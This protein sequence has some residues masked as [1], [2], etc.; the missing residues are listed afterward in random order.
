[1][2]TQKA[3]KRLK[4]GN[5]KRIE[6][7]EKNR[8]VP[9]MINKNN[10]IIKSYGKINVHNTRYD[11]VMKYLEDNF[12]KINPDTL[13]KE[14]QEAYDLL[15]DQL[16][17]IRLKV[18]EENIERV[19]NNPN[20]GFGHYLL[21]LIS[22]RAWCGAGTAIFK[23]IEDDLDKTHIYASD[24]ICRDHDIRYNNARTLEEQHEADIIMLKE[25]FE[26]YFVS[27]NKNLFGKYETDF[28]NW[29]KGLK[30]VSNYLISLL[31]G[32][33]I[34]YFT[35]SSINKLY[36]NIGSIIKIPFNMYK[37]Y[38]LEKDIINNLIGEFQGGNLN[39][40]MDDYNELIEL[41]MK[42]TNNNNVK[43]IMGT[44]KAILN[45]IKDVG[46]TGLV[47]DKILA[48]GA[49]LGIIAKYSFEKYAISIGKEDYDIDITE[50]IVPLR[51]DEFSKENEDLIINIYEELMTK[52]LNKDIVID[53]N[54]ID[55]VVIE[56][57][58]TRELMD[59][60]E[61]I[62]IMNKTFTDKL[63]NLVE[64]KDAPE[65]TK[66]DIE[67]GQDLYVDLITTEDP[68][69]THN[70]INMDEYLNYMSELM[71]DP[72]FNINDLSEDSL[73]FITSLF[74][75]DDE[76][77]GTTTEETLTDDNLNNIDND[78]N[79]GTYEQ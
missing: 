45:I 10:E 66:E 27:F 43:E 56:P 40:N 68:D 59:D 41:Y 22:Y 33:Y 61:E 64:H 4:R 5:Y 70:K 63:Y 53:R 9:S 51:A 52:I 25:I 69:I 36:E 44:D 6:K 47:F 12:N 55:N 42:E 11:K 54:D 57:I 1:M 46:F 60:I 58:Y 2:N 35:L 32:A 21:S 23:N 49:M 30:T 13:T 14:Q 74:F 29:Q 39:V 76:N 15:K 38:N 3:L 24:N 26:R 62:H 20:E 79:S 65:P 71:N 17:L 18:L 8:L 34:S 75:N 78:E 77:T 48:I 31:E 16:S 7:A 73:D 37:R 72:N 67:I 28:S 19:E 50:G